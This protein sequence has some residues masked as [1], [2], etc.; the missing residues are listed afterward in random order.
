MMH[1]ADFESLTE[2]LDKNATFK[3]PKGQMTG[4][5]LQAEK[6][7]GADDD[8]RHTVTAADGTPTPAPAAIALPSTVVDQQLHLPVP[9]HSREARQQRAKAELVVRP[10]GNE[11]WTQGELAAVHAAAVR[12]GP[13][14]KL[15]QQKQE[16]AGGGGGKPVPVPGAVEPAYTVLYQ[17]QVRAEDV[18]LGV[19]FTR[20]ESSAG[21]D[22]VVVKVTLPLAASSAGIALHVSAWQL[23]LGSAEYYLSAPLPRRVVAGVADAK[24]DGE[25]KVLSVRLTSDTTDDMR[26]L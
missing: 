4:Y 6:G 25:V 24:W 8:A 19:D 20:D 11:I 12:A 26:V 3:R 7:G 2:M 18:F 22:G 23:T 17:Q 16:S 9:T 10:R 14:G 1:A 5:S 21:S 13:A 15:Q